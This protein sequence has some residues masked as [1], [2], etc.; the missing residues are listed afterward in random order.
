MLSL[1]PYI[2]WIHVLSAI[3]A[4]GTNLTYN[5]ILASAGQHKDRLAFSLKTIHILDSR[6]ANPAYALLLIT[7]LTMALSLRLPLTT[8]WLLTALILYG[9]IA[10]LGIAIYAP[11]FRRQVRLLE[12]EGPQSPA[13]QS[14]ARRANAIGILVT[15]LA[16]FIVFLM[17]T[18]PALWGG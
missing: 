12:Q 11:A 16:V 14:T 1:F 7:G 4:V 2:K 10:T 6:M 9:L 8:P 13:Y 3:V 17:V 18:Q 5:V 15:F